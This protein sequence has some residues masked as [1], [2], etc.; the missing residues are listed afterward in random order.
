MSSLTAPLQQLALQTKASSLKAYTSRVGKPV[1]VCLS[2][3][4]IGTAM[5]VVQIDGYCKV[6]KDCTTRV[7]VST[8]QWDC[9]SGHNLQGT[10]QSMQQRGR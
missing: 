2:A 10:A 6:Q 5:F 1:L 4:M 3:A 7:L 8:R 9:V